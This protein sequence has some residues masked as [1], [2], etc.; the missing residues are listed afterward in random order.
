MAVPN[1]FRFARWFHRLPQKR[2]RRVQ[3]DLPRPPRA[4]DGIVYL[5]TTTS[6]CEYLM[7]TFAA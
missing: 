7:N 3:P 6:A 2:V 4:Y 1:L 5:E